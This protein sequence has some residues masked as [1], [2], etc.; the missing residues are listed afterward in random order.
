MLLGTDKP[1]LSLTE[2]EEEGLDDDDEMEELVSL[3]AWEWVEGLYPILTDIPANMCM[4][5][6]RGRLQMYQLY[7]L[8]SRGVCRVLILQMGKQRPRHIQ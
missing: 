6:G 2:E 4:H 7:T 5:G 1:H 3:L 8:Q